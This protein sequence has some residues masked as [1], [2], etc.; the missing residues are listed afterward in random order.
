MDLNLEFFKNSKNQLKLNYFSIL[1]RNVAF[2]CFRKG[3]YHRFSITKHLTKE[4]K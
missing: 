3:K 2:G 1:N 4:I